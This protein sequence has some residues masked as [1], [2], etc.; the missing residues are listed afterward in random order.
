MEE[1]WR[2]IGGGSE[3]DRRRIGVE[4][5]GVGV[6]WRG[7]GG[8][9]EE[10]RGL[11]TPQYGDCVHEEDWRRIGRGSEEDWTRLEED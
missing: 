3:E 6:D 11:V 4:W 10:D 8:G 5:R 1:E 9:L 7:I 2:R